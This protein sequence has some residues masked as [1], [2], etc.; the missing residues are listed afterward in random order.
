MKIFI[1]QILTP[2]RYA[3]SILGIRVVYNRLKN[4]GYLRTARQLQYHARVELE[5]LRKRFAER[6]KLAAMRNWK[7]LERKGGTNGERKKSMDTESKGR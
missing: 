7:R 5:A 1:S 6:R 4:L 3:C 2:V